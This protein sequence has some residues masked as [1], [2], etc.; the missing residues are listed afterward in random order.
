MAGQ[1]KKAFVK[2]K[3]LYAKRPLQ[4]RAH[5]ASSGIGASFARFL[6]HKG[7]TVLLNGRRTDR[8]DSLAEEISVAGGRADVFPADLSVQGERARMAEEIQSRYALDVLINNAGFGWYGYYHRMP[9]DIAR[10]MMATNMEAAAHLTRLFLPA[11]LSA[12]KG[13][14]V[15]IGSIAGVFPNQG[16]AL[17]SATK[18]FLNGWSTALHRELRG[19]GVHASVMNLGPVQTEFFDQARE[20]EGGRPIPAERF[21]IPVER[22]NLALWRLLRRPRRAIYVP[23]WLSLS[24]YADLLFGGLVDRI[25]P[26]LLRRKEP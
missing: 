10:R 19:S 6:A 21:S 15:N 11:M 14:V 25:G 2:K 26:L 20:I 7:L 24:K 18:S 22:V 17:Y 9:W 8:L 16:V 5:G 1:R 3:I 23:A 12:R 13:H 4:R